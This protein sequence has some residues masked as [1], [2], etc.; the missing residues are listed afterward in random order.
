M[1]DIKTIGLLTMFLLLFTLGSLVWVD[2]NISLEHSPV[3]SEMLAE[4][5]RLEHELG[6]KSKSSLIPK[7]PHQLTAREAEKLENDIK[8]LKKEI[9]QERAEIKVAEDPR[10]IK[11]IQGQLSRKEIELRELEEKTRLEFG[12][13]EIVGQEQA[14]RTKG[15]LERIG[16]N[17]AVLF[18]SFA[19]FEI[20]YVP[21]W[22]SFSTSLLICV[23]I[24]A[25]LFNLAND[26][27]TPIN[28]VLD[29]MII[30][31]FGIAIGAAFFSTIGSGLFAKLGDA[32]VGGLT[33]LGGAIIDGITTLGNTIWDAIMG[34]GKWT[35]DKVAGV[36]EWA[37]G[38]LTSLWEG[39]KSIW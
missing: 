11:R 19:K 14:V 1:V 29:L 13:A 4:K 39:I 7:N 24:G 5:A 25:V 10:V 36:V 2:Y 22:L 16:E 17:F 28:T 3:P 21:D 6:L 20:P 31:V 37:K 30:I 33:G 12:G 23:G 18:N 26:F 15:A 32:I 8:K 34:V 35:A 38:G 9:A 27:A